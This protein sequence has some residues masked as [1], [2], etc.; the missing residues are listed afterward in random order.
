MKTLVLAC[1]LAAVAGCAATQ[2]VNNSQ[3]GWRLKSDTV[4][5][6]VT[7]NGGHM[8]PVT[9]CTDTGSPVQPYYISVSAGHDRPRVQ[10]KCESP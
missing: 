10:G 3:A 4:N 5:L 7:R 9:F 6:F 1:L 2:N 8:A